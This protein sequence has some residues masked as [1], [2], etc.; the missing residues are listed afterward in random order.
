MKSR[1]SKT[2][3][4]KVVL[5][6]GFNTMNAMQFPKPCVCVCVRARACVHVCVNMVCSERVRVR[7]ARKKVALTCSEN[8]AWHM[9]IKVG[10]IISLTKPCVQWY[11][12]LYTLRDQVAAK[13]A[14]YR[15]AL[16]ESQNWASLG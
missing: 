1:K 16:T 8:M 2:C 13:T 3:A 11:P 4:L 10:D 14:R 15:D 9:P 5:S 6:F 7:A 12:L